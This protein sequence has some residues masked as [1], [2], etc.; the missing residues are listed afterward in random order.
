[1]NWVLDCSCWSQRMLAYCQETLAIENALLL[2]VS[3]LR[4]SSYCR[5]AGAGPEDLTP[6]VKPR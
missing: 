3:I 2:T 4:S 1:M 5:T 6:V